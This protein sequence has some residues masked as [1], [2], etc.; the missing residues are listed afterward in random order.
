MAKIRLSPFVSI[1]PVGARVLVRSDLKSFV[2]SGAGASEFFQRARPLLDGQHGADEILELFPDYGA[3]GVRAILEDLERRGVLETAER[4]AD[5]GEGGRDE[6]LAAYLSF[7]GSGPREPASAFERAHVA[8]VGATAW[9]AAAC[10]ELVGRG[11]GRL[12]LLDARPD[13]ATPVDEAF[14]AGL[15]EELQRCGAATTLDRRVLAAGDDL[16]ARPPQDASL[17][18]VAVHPDELALLAAVARWAQAGR[19]RYLLAHVEGLSAVLG[20]VVVPG[21][22][23]C[24]ECLR[25]RRLANDPAF[26][27]TAL[28]Q[29]RLLSGAGGARRRLSP[30]GAAALL[31]GLILGEAVKLLT[32]YAPSQLVG[33]Q[34]DFDLLHHSARVHDLVRLPWCPV[35]GGAAALGAPEAGGRAGGGSDLGSSREPADLRA[36]LAGWVD[37]RTGIVR[38]LVLNEPSPEQPHSLSTATAVVPGPAVP[39]GHHHAAE[40]LVGSGK[41]TTRVAAMLGAVGEAI[42]RYS[43]SVYRE[44]DLVRASPAKLGPEAFD[45]VSLCLYRPEQY[46]APGFPYDRYDPTREI[47]WTSARWLDSGKPVLV[48]ALVTYFDYR[49]PAGERY[50]QVTSSGLAA[51]ASHEDAALR[52]TLE[53]IERDAFM[54]TWLERRAPRAVAV[55]E[56]LGPDVLEVLSEL[57]EL[58]LDTRLY[59]MASEV[60][61]PSFMCVA[62][63][64]GQ[65]RPAASVALAAHHDPVEAARK[66]VLEQAHVGP[67]VA[68]L[69]KDPSQKVP[70]AAADVR[71]L[72]DH[73]LYYVPRA[74]LGAFDFIRTADDRAVPLSRLA[75]PAGGAEACREALAAAGV[76]VAVADVTA[77]DV[78]LGPFR[79]AR[80]LGTYLQPI[81]FGHGQRRLA[82]PRLSAAVS[83]HPHPLA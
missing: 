67:Y 46:A 76:R 72:N 69:M 30:P 9:A 80:A 48:P 1:I 47:S 4:F 6:E 59:L 83:P 65:G 43:A 52:A 13:A 2:L 37:D 8:V 82:N 74:R 24:W 26:E 40:P 35:C 54:M 15:L 78:R 14:A 18:L 66:A 42:E 70:K 23:A 73:A 61:I 45:P 53:L 32:G 64:D 17:L 5:R 79:V 10:R 75:R 36:K 28:L 77:P 25:S 7:W 29:S 34:L 44:R 31:G 63:G 62:W 58:G 21:E 50:C 56:E 49:A 3:Q 33:R 57:R 22:T 39:G 71:T 60:A 16:M 11:V 51:G 55:G 12:T 68:R 19:L 41:G 20:P 81:D 27:E 38:Q